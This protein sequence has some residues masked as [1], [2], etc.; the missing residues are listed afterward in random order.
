MRGVKPM[1][2]IL[3]ELEEVLTEMVEDHDLQWGDVLSLVHGYLMVHH[4]EAQ[5]KYDEGGSPSF[6]YG[7]VIDENELMAEMEREVRHLTK[8]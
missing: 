3:L 8:K 1:G 5:E 6:I 7:P 2:E 4:P